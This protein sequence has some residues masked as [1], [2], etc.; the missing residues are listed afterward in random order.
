MHK[1]SLPEEGEES[2]AVDSVELA[3]A[4]N[5]ENQGPGRGA[6]GGAGGAQATPSPPRLEFFVGHGQQ[7]SGTEAA[8]DFDGGEAAKIVGK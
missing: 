3:L 5:A 2:L 7:E 8:L 6:A 4:L 1:L